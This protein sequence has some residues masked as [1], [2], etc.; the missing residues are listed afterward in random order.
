MRRVGALKVSVGIDQP[1]S[2]ILQPQRRLRKVVISDMLFN[3]LLNLLR[4]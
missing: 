2:G 4:N 1:D 3:R